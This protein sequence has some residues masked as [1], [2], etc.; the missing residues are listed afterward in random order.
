MVRAVAPRSLPGPR[1]CAAEGSTA[2]MDVGCEGLHL[3]ATPISNC[4]PA[5]L[6]QFP[7]SSPN[8]PNSS[9][10]PERSPFAVAARSR[11]RF[12]PHSLQDQRPHTGPHRPPPK[13]K[14][15][16]NMVGVASRSPAVVRAQ[17]LQRATHGKVH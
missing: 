14:P 9:K 17:V 13:P 2:W 7:T 15:L 8:P 10:C 6:C 4:R 16:N 1:P 3:I 11:P 12:C 5:C